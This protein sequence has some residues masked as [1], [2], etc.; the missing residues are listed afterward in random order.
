MKQGITTA[1]IA[2]FLR[3]FA[4][5]ISAGI[6]LIQSCEILEKSQEKAACRTLIYSIKREILTGKTLFYCLSQHPNQFDKLTCHLIQMGEH[7]G[8]LEQMLMLIAHH[9][10]K[11]IA[12]KKRIKQA[13]FYPC[14]I[15]IM[16]FIVTICMLLFIIP[17]FAALF[18]ETQ[19]SLPFLTIC[20]FSLSESLQ[21]HLGLVAG[22][23]LASAIYLYYGLRHQ[24]LHLRVLQL[25]I[26][27][28]LVKP[29][30]NK[31]IF[32]RFAR[33]LAITFSAGLSITDSLSLIAHTTGQVTFANIIHRLSYH[34]QSGMPL[35]QAMVILAYFPPFMTQMVKI[36]EESGMLEA[37][38]DKI[39]D[40]LEAETDQMMKL[41][42]QLLEPLIMIVLGV[43]IGGLVVGMYLPLFKLGSAL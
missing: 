2:I 36:G 14:L 38:L 8:K 27:L 24:R 35:H 42:N 19:T 3:Q 41:L 4:T 34:I 23:F 16:A 32:A 9:H 25:L 1:D 12:F 11:K 43:L 21:H 31:I 7:T 15:A 28:P 40:F 20:I 18:H 26:Q 33:H 10:E 13:L 37:M 30:A 39:A 5:L 6:P 17:H 22:F 29:C